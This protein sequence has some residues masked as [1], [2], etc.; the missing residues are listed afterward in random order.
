MKL[1]FTKIGSLDITSDKIDITDPC[2]CRET[3]CRRTEP[4]VPGAYDCYVGTR[5]EKFGEVVH[6]L[7]L[8]SAQEEHLSPSLQT[9]IIG[10]IGVDAG[11]AGFFEGKPDYDDE[12]WYKLCDFL[13]EPTDGIQRRY[14]IGD[15][16]SPMKCKCVL[17]IS[18]YGDGDYD[19]YSITKNGK[20]VGYKLVF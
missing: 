13:L 6:E 12:T 19:V 2:Y 15:E 11:L 4:I 10:T 14:W 18:G 17:S 3:W 16:S 1:N 5:A 20:L 8:L 9:Q 7:T